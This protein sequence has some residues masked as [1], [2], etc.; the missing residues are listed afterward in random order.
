LPDQGL[1]YPELY[2]PEVRATFAAPSVYDAVIEGARAA[3][4]DTVDVRAGLAEQRAPYLY[5]RD[6]SHFTPAAIER[7]AAL[8]APAAR[9][10]VSEPAR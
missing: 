7:V 9:S 5:L 10:S 2:S 1:L 6:D 4:V 8:I 3:G